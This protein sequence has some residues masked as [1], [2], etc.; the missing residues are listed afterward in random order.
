MND[1]MSGK[2]VETHKELLKTKQ[3]L[4]RMNTDDT[5]MKEKVKKTKFCRGST[6]IGADQKK[7][8]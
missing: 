5:D 3:V 7:K 4:P 2:A 1:V 8:M 6:R